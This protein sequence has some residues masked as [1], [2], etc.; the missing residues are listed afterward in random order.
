MKI[1]LEADICGTRIKNCFLNA[2]GPRDASLA[3]LEEIAS[4]KAGA[5]VTKTATIDPRDGNPKPRYFENSNGSLNSMGLPNLGYKEYVKMVPLLKKSGKPVICSALGM[6]EKSA[7]HFLEIAKA[8]FSAGADLVELNLSCPNVVGKPQ[9]G[10]DFETTERII[11]TV[12]AELDSSKLIIK[13]PPYFDFCHFEQAAGII[14]DYKIGSIAC[15]NS[16][17]NALI[18]D[19]ENEQAVISPKGGFGGI[20]GKFVKPT[21]LANVRK[22]YE[23]LGK[24]VCIIGIGGIENGTDAFE[25]ILCGATAVGIGTAFMKEG[26]ACF[27]RLESELKAVMEKKK[28]SS[29]DDFRG[30]LKTFSKEIKGTKDY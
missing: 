18:V 11:K 8:F 17:G 24:N 30:K 3:E 15:I 5:I 20:G 1:S 26:P 28:Y 29:L 10:Y 19:S 21:A 6:G 25:H 9:A 13:L 23:L 22:F 4:S 14:K 2:S 16:I 27:A 7:E 12:C